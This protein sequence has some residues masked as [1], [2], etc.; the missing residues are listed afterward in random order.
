M[1]LCSIQVKT[2]FGWNCKAVLFVVLVFSRLFHFMVFPQVV[3]GESAVAGS[4]E[5][6]SP[7]SA[8]AS[9]T[10]GRHARVSV[11]SCGGDCVWSTKE[12]HSQQVH[13]VWEEVFLVAV[14]FFSLLCFPIVFV[15]WGSIFLPS[16]HLPSSLSLIIPYF[17][18]CLIIIQSSSNIPFMAYF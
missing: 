7:S 14:T 12:I 1:P 10:A 11:G 8:P 4:G 16:F 3:F 13:N 9:H 15:P 6:P 5:H 18:Q 2:A 17:Y